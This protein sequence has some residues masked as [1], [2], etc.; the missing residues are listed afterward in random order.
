MLKKKLNPKENCLKCGECLYFKSHC[1]PGAKC[2][3]SEEGVKQFTIAP[4]CFFPDITQITPSINAFAQLASV[5]SNYTPKQRRIAIALLK[6][7][8][9]YAKKQFSFGMKVYISV[10]GDGSYLSDYV[11][12]FV[13]GY[14]SEGKVILSGMPTQRTLGSSF[15]AFMC[16]SSLLTY[17]EFEKIKEKCEAEGRINNPS[18]RKVKRINS[19]IDRYEPEV[20]TIDSVPRSW[21]TKQDEKP[22]KR[23]KK[24]DVFEKITTVLGY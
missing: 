9:K 11:S 3:C 20:P 19:S 18:L 1:R 5:F 22:T 13:L 2:P 16:E 12:A 23:S 6:S 10:R 17:E 21:L 15:I 7:A 8:P 24:T 4:I 14:N